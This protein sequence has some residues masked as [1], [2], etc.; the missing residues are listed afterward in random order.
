L[1]TWLDPLPLRRAKLTTEAARKKAE[2]ARAP[3]ETAT[4]IAEAARAE[5]D[6]AVA[7][8]SRLVAEVCTLVCVCVCSFRVCTRFHVVYSWFHSSLISTASSSLFFFFLAQAESFLEEV[9]NRPGSA[10]GTFWWMDRELTEI[11]KYK[12]TSRGGIAK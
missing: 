7:E 8:A 1:A 10:K 3:F 11:K 6:E 9:R 2:K 12:P 4:K 5:A